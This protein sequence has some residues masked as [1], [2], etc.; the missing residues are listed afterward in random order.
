MQI[1]ATVNIDA[2]SLKVKYLREAAR[3]GLKFGV[4]EAGLIV[5]T[6]AKLLVPVKTGKLRDAIHTETTR[7]EA[8]YQE[9]KVT[10]VREAANDWGIEPAYARRIEFGF[11][12]TDRLG[13]VYNQP[14]QPYMR[15][16]GDTKAG[17][18][19]AAIIDGVRGQMID[20]TNISSRRR[21]A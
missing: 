9:V 21:A 3:L 15:T 12:G 6:E 18:V 4:S 10:P 7:N 16:A 17:E 19:K 5:E 20:A 11:V 14:A 1:T 8:E 2:L 13:R